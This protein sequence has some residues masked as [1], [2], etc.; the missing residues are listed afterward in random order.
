[1]SNL[2]N[3][4]PA[5]PP[6][7]TAST[8]EPSTTVR[9]PAPAAA[10]RAEL[11]ELLADDVPYGDPTTEALGIGAMPGTMQFAARDRMVLALAEDAAAIAELAGCR[12][13]RFASSGSLLE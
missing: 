12:V 1:M 7:V 13:E 3:L 5:A 9:W 2:A 11:E 8:T 4:R 10:S 6:A